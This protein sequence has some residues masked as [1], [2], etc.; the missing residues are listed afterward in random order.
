MATGGPEV[1]RRQAGPQLWDI[2][3]AAPGAG[4]GR[5]GWSVGRDCGMMHIPFPI[6]NA[7]GGRSSARSLAQVIPAWAALFHEAFRILSSVTSRCCHQVF[8]I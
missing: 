5:L 2:D 4:G 8:L 6:A 1:V 3:H 7:A